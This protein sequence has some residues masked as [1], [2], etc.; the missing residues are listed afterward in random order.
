MARLEVRQKGEDRDRRGN[1]V[2]GAIKPDGR[3]DVG[4]KEQCRRSC[5][6]SI[7]RSKSRDLTVRSSELLFF[8]I[9]SCRLSSSS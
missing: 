4:T 6:P 5:D 9:I 2:S 3:A 8:S 1:H 7:R